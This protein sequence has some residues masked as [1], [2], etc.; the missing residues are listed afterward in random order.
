MSSLLL[1]LWFERL[2]GDQDK[3]LACTD[4]FLSEE[5]SPRRGAPGGTRGTRGGASGGGGHRGPRAARVPRAPNKKCTATLIK[6]KQNTES[7]SKGIAQGI[8]QDIPPKE[9]CGVHQEGPPQDPLR[10][11]AQRIPDGEPPEEQGIPKGFRGGS[12]GNPP[13]AP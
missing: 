11:R 13:T 10:G 7:A 3:S 9:S 8:A 12:L 1:L 4:A 5:I 6:K 2:G